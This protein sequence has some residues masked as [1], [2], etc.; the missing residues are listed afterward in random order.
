MEK[1]SEGT[2]RRL[3]RQAYNDLYLFAKFVLGY[4]RLLPHVHR[5]PCASIQ[6]VK[7]GERHQ[8]LM[9]RGYFKSR[10]GAIALP[11]FRLI[12]DPDETNYIMSH[13]LALT[14]SHLREIKRHIRSGKLDFY[15][16]T[17]KPMFDPAQKWTED[18]IE[19][20]WKS[21]AVRGG[22]PSIAIGSVEVGKEGFHFDNIIED[23]LHDKDNVQTRDGIEKV[24]YAHQQVTPLQDVGRGSRRYLIGTRWAFGDLPEYAEKEEGWPTDTLGLYEEDGETCTFP[25]EFTPERI[26][27]LKK[28]MAPELFAAQ[29]L[30]EPIS[31]ETQVFRR[32]MFHPYDPET[33]PKGTR[34]QLLDP[35]LSL[36]K[37]G[38]RSG[39]IQATI[40]PE[41][42]I[43]V[44]TALGERLLPDQLIDRFFAMAVAF[45]PD[46]IGIE[47]VAFQKALKYEFEKRMRA[48]GRWWPVVELK[49]DTRISKE[50]RIKGL[51]G[52]YAAGDILHAPGLNDLED[53]LLRFPK[54]KHDDLID[55]LAYLPLIAF[56]GKVP[57]V[58]NPEE[59]MLDN[60]LPSTTIDT[61]SYS[62]GRLVNL[63]ELLEEE[64]V[65]WYN[66]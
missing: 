28:G 11:L 37:H 21:S 32:S 36:K 44:S 6:G 35:A 58:Y 10:I 29:Y 56:P 15:S 14:K 5:K 23:D 9:P 63:E 40:S 22:T 62:D 30:N 55:A 51:A 41:N 46:I 38:D 48:A 19:I 57:G 4:D 31:A 17:G 49:P 66:L 65:D 52:I 39:V 43:Y 3:Y 16:R 45:N 1:K 13:S 47:T 61:V 12:H 50:E 25:E 24:I 34:Y 53:E 26:A 27:A 64:T 42:R 2:K 33:A 20:G 8:N 60:P 7:R 18:E 59:M 54:G